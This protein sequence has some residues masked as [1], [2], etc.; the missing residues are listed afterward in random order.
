M[1]EPKEETDNSTII[2]ADFNAL[3]S[4]MDRMTRQKINKEI[5]DLNNTPYLN[6]H[7]KW[8]TFYIAPSRLSIIKIS[9][10]PRVIWIKHGLHKNDTQSERKGNLQN[11][12]FANHISDKGLISRIYKEL[13]QLN[14]TTTNNPIKNE[15]RNSIDISPK[16]MYKWPTSI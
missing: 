8:V 10:P 6:S 7:N 3:L 12:R 4:I 5:E 2:V 9:F 16:M 15:Q 1:T 14:N 11:G 13:L